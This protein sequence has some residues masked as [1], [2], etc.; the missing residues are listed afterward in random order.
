MSSSQA[1]PH[2]AGGGT[3]GRLAATRLALWEAVDR[4]P[5]DDREELREQ[6][7]SLIDVLRADFDDA[8]PAQVD[9]IDELELIA[10]QLRYHDARQL[11]EGEPGREFAA[12]CL[13]CD[14]FPLDAGE[15]C[16]DCGSDRFLSALR[17]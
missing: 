4:L 5:E 6:L 3:S 8:S 14:K 16:P 15:A 11:T 1:K 13:R 12:I 7:H 10:H 17:I 2:E 9:I